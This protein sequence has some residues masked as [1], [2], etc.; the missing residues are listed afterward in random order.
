MR[1]STEYR[2]GDDRNIRGKSP[3][4]VLLTFLG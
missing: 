3:Y 1:A 2:D 4:P